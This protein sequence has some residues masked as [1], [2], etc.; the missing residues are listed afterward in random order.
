VEGHTD[1]VGDDASNFT[2]SQ[3]RSEAVR[4]YVISKGIDESRISARGYGETK[5]IADNKTPEGRAL[6]RRVEVKLY[7]SR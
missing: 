7:Y 6:N 3:K 2:L 1:N 4:E 5:P